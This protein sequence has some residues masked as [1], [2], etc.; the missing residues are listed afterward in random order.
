MK[1]R[2]NRFK[3][4]LGNLC[5]SGI[6][7]LFL[8]LFFSCGKKLY[9]KNDFPFYDEAFKLEASSVLRTDGVYVL[10]HIWTD[11]NG[12]TTKPPKNHTFY[13]FYKTGQCNL[14]LDLSNEI[15]SKEDYFNVINKD[16]EEK[17]NTLFEGYY[18]LQNNK[19]VIQSAVVPR[20]QFEFKYGYVE[21]DSLILVKSTIDRKGKFDDKHFTKNYKEYYIFMPLDIKNERD[22]KW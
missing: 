15:K 16:F 6:V 22:P 9:Q 21:K 5:K 20:Q 11:E 2:N 14:T 8:G 17:K 19:I 10:D 1:D 13:K 12:G 7:I 4:K 3:L 18:K